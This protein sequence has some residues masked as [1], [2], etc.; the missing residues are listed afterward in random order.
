MLL[1]EHNADREIF[2][3]LHLSHSDTQKSPNVEDNES[4]PSEVKLV[5]YDPDSKP[6][7]LGRPRRNITNTLAPPESSS[8]KNYNEAVMSKFRLDSQPIEG[9]G[10]RGE[11]EVE[12]V[13]KA[14]SLQHQ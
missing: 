1:N 4:K 12:K 13:L 3:D 14:E 9:P 2:E 11:K 8:S 6:P 5:S 7:R 10:S